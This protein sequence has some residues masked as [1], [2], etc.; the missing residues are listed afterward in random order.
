M[1][2]I[3]SLFVGLLAMGLVALAAPVSA[4]T[5]TSESFF[6]ES[7]ADGVAISVMGSSVLDL[8][9]TAAAAT[10]DEAAA[11]AV[12]AAVADNPAGER[13]AESVGETVSDP[14]DPAEACEIAVPEPVS[15]VLG[16]GVLCG[17]AV[18]TGDVPEARGEA[19]VGDVEVLPLGGE[20]LAELADLLA[21]LGVED[22]LQDVTDAV[23][24][25]V[26]DQLF[27]ELLD[28][29]E[30][31]LE[32]LGDEVVD[33]LLG[34]LDPVLDGLSDADENLADLLDDAATLLGE[35]LPET[36]AA[37]IEFLDLDDG[38]L[39][40]LLDLDSLTEALLAE[41]QALLHVQLLGTVSEAGADDA[42]VEARAGGSTADAAVGLRL[43]LAGLGDV[44]DDLVEEA[45]GNLVGTL[46]GIVA[47][48]PL[49]GS[50][51]AVDDL[52]DQVFSDENPVT[53]LLADDLLFVSIAPGAAVVSYDIDAE[54]FDG[55]ATA[56]VV[57]LDGPL[58]QLSDAVN[59][60]VGTV[61]DALLSELG[62]SPLADVIEVSLLSEN[63]EEDEVGG[64]PGLRATSGVASVT[65]LRAAGG[66]I[67]VDVTAS[68][69]GVGYEAIGPVAPAGTEPEPV[70]PV[71]KQPLPVTGGAGLL[72]GMLA[73]GG[74]TALRRRD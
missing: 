50:L 18:A 25:Q 60:L 53:A 52:L 61:D 37:L 11:L 5:A 8:S 71:E 2:R 57:A 41:G 20:A 62:D 19:S 27:A 67:E 69:A 24:A 45:L 29:C 22:L 42:S 1:P 49:E 51:P 65:L 13:L 21:D 47:G 28:G 32:G 12:P 17:E 33:P 6:A 43:S 14:G 68:M 74:V 48:T 72:M 54:E 38:T 10:V 3:R 7:G 73:L 35:D 58:L 40:S 44:L 4:Q 56:A 59:E 36:C 26:T 66:G 31:A 46:D 15:A 23:G 30:A 70:E 63:V 64:L 34:G 16:L 39:S 9:T 55:D